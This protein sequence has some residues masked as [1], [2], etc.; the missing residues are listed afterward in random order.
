MLVLAGGI[1]GAWVPAH[2]GRMVRRFDAGNPLSILTVLFCNVAYCNFLQQ[3]QE[4]FF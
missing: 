1:A 3:D 4:P 2:E